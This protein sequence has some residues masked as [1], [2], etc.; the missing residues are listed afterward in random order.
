VL[1]LASEV[2]LLSNRE[3][4]PSQG[5]IICTKDFFITVAM[6]AIA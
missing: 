6:M 4:P 1:K 5:E 3:S 2:F